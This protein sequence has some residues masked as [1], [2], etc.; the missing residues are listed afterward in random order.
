[1]SREGAHKT[2]L[3]E[4]LGSMHQVCEQLG[5][6]TSVTFFERGNYINMEAVCVCGRVSLVNIVRVS[7][8][9]RWRVIQKKKKKGAVVE[10]CYI[11]SYTQ[12]LF[13][14]D[15]GG[16]L[17]DRSDRESVEQA[18]GRPAFF[19]GVGSIT[20]PS[21]NSHPVMFFEDDSEKWRSRRTHRIELL[22]VR[23]RLFH[24]CGGSGLIFTLSWGKRM[25]R[26]EV[27]EGV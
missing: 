23:K 5:S 9:D 16:G 13:E 3:I 24:D 27:K 6:S 21:T 14:T 1:M 2:R 19:S 17:S 12:S 25:E 26:G 22:A 20:L 4:I 7:L 18:P 8:T 15:P 10:P 11:W